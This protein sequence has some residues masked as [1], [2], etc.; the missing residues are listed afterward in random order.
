MTRILDGEH[1]S[2]DLPVFGSC[3]QDRPMLDYLAD[4]NRVA[5]VGPGARAAGSR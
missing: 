2:V 5:A 4:N 3:G 1:I